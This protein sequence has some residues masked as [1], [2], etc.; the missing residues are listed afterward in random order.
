VEF[1]DENGDSMI[2][3]EMDRN[4]AWH[5]DNAEPDDVDVTVRFMDAHGHHRLRR[6][7]SVELAKGT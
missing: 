6:V 3:G 1:V 4:N 7:N 2:A 5:S